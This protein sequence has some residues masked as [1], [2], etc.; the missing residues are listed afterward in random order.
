MKSLIQ[1]A[2][3]QDFDTLQEAVDKYE[4]CKPIDKFANEFNFEQWKEEN[5]DVEAIKE[6]L[7]NLQKWEKDTSVIKPQENKGLV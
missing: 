5:E 4:L 2:I 1:A 6:Q 3:S 7:A